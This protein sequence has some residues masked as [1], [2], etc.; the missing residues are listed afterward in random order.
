M[1][2]AGRVVLGTD[3]GRRLWWTRGRD[4]AT[5]ARSGCD[6]CS[7]AADGALVFAP[8]SAMRPGQM[9]TLVDERADVVDVASTVIDLAVRNYLFIEE[10]PRERFGRGDWLLRRRNDAGHELLPY[11][12]E[13][14]DTLFTAATTSS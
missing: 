12:R 2:G 13:V 8:P 3:R 7:T 10:Q 11:E 1:G 4:R 6:R 14:F 9:G 5:T